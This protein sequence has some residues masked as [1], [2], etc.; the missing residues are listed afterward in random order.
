MDH[1]FF[2]GVDWNALSK[3]QIQAPYIPAIGSLDD[4]SNFGTYDEERTFPV[5]TGDQ[6]IFNEF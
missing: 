3:K 1:P 5:Y 6:E 2:S 4:S